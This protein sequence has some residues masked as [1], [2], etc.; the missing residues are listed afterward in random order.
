MKESH[1]DASDRLAINEGLRKGGW[2]CGFQNER[3]IARRMPKII[4]TEFRNF[5]PEAQWADYRRLLV[6]R[7]V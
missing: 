6:S 2:I 3:E 7:G 1:V 4:P 5:P